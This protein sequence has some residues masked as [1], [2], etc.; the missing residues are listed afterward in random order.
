MLNPYTYAHDYLVHK[1]HLQACGMPMCDPCSRWR[2]SVCLP[3]DVQTLVL[4]DGKKRKNGTR[5][6]E[7]S[8]LKRQW[9]ALWLSVIGRVVD[10]GGGA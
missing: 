4:P 8:S 1:C 9:R 10:I 7:T 5:N 6:E 2:A 3:A